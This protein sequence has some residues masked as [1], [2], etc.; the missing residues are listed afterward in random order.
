MTLNPGE[1]A[2]LKCTV[3]EYSYKPCVDS[4]LNSR[5]R[6]MIECSYYDYAVAPLINRL[7]PVGK[8]WTDRAAEIV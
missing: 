2:Y 1:Q 4:G 6:P 5:L 3:I 8:W 7:R